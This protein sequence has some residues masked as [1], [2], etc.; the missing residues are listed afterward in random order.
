MNLNSIHLKPAVP[1]VLPARDPFAKRESEKFIHSSARFVLMRP[2]GTPKR[3]P[4]TD[5][6][7]RRPACI[8]VTGYGAGKTLMPHTHTH[9]LIVWALY[10]RICEF[11]LPHPF[12]SFGSCTPDDGSLVCWP[13]RHI[14]R[15]LIRVVSR[16]QRF[17]KEHD[18]FRWNDGTMSCALMSTIAGW[19]NANLSDGEFR[20]NYTWILLVWLYLQG[21]RRNGLPSICCAGNP[22]L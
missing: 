4:R 9:T 20:L 16:L 22:A 7:T 15:E 17:S 21:L 11:F 18:L 8:A 3:T 1:S 6:G 10:C 14:G 13:G 12:R 5:D 2:D 19:M